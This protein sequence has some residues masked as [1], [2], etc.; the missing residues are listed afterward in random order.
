VEPAA[1]PFIHIAG[2]AVDERLRLIGPDGP[3]IEVPIRPLWCLNH[4][5]PLV[6]ALLAERGIGALQVAIC[7]REI[8]EGKFVSVV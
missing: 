7:R 6:E 1:H 3:P 4:W 2:L 8:A 5:R